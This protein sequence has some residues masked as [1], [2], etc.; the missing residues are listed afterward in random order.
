MAVGSSSRGA[1]V[2]PKRVK[3]EAIP[4]TSEE[5]DEG[6]DGVVATGVGGYSLAG[7]SRGGF[8]TQT[9]GK[10][11]ATVAAS[12]EGYTASRS[13]NNSPGP[14]SSRGAGN[15]S[16][17]PPLPRLPSRRS[18][19]DTQTVSSPS[20][21]DIDEPILPPSKILPRLYDTAMNSPDR[22]RL[23][24][25]IRMLARSVALYPFPP[26]ALAAAS[27]SDALASHPTSPREEL[28]QTLAERPR[29]KPTPTPVQIYLSQSRHLSKDAP[30]ELRA[31]T[32]ELM[33]ACLEASIGSTGGIQ[34]GEKA[35]YW[36]E[37]RRWSE[38]AKIEVSDGQGGIRRLLPGA[39]REALV[40]VLGALTKG[41]RD[42]SDVP[43]LVSLLCTFVTD[44]LPVPRPP[45]PLFDPE[46]K[47]H[48]VRST[49]PRPS[50]HT[51]SLALLTALHKFSA[52]HIY[53]SSTLLALRATLE[54]A[55]LREEGDLG[56]QSEVGVIAFLGAVVR[57]GEVTGGKS[58]RR[59]AMFDAPTSGNVVDSTGTN[60]NEGDEILREVVSVVARII[61]C[62]GLVGVIDLE[63]GQRDP[64]SHAPPSHMSLLPPLALELMRDLIRSPANQALKSLRNTLVAPP[65]SSPR[66]ATPILLL[67]GTLRALRKAYV[68]QNSIELEASSKSSDTTG[69]AGG[70]SRFP[71]LLSL[72]L[73]WIWSGLQRVMQW[74]S[75]RVDA[76]VLRLLE[77]R[78]DAAE[79]SGRS[80]EPMGG[81]RG[82]ADEAGAEG[83]ASYEDWDMAIEVL[84]K[85]KW[86]IGAWETAKGKPWVLV[87]LGE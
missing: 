25:L 9:R 11:A 47:T 24:P 53:T 32:L 84:S 74:Q 29:A 49:P 85:A 26:P 16:S 37:V 65:T 19:V 15:F 10:T 43:G 44:S 59:K 17:A 30:D 2:R 63:P 1:G 33:L 58:A 28:Q 77:E 41:G 40:A 6:R 18:S 54:V 64:S 7:P 69:A 73:P 78:L 62:E 68:E 36:D 55:R 13:R 22:S 20:H 82:I 72:G 48:F 39:D 52:P 75:G 80:R 31:A 66:P 57:F 81:E 45:S 23:V 4:I 8:V 56:G 79:K 38:E 27:L 67:V 12:Y 46:V 87:E 51:S 83:G 5:N 60:P 21:H 14:T 86:H 70:E 71:S 42:L 50:P 34:E 61:G 35:V 76:E 3:S